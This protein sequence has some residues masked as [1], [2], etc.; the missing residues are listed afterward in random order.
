MNLD[1]DTR[2][3]VRHIR[4]SDTPLTPKHMA[5]AGRFLPPDSTLKPLT[6]HACAAL[7]ERCAIDGLRSAPRKALKERD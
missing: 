5:A 3:S 6:H 4:V 1:D 7:A 2:T